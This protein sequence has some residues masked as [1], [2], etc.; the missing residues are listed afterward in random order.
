[1][2]KIYCFYI[3]LWSSF[4]SIVL[5][6]VD[7]CVNIFCWL[8]HFWFY[9]FPLH[10]N[11]VYLFITVL[12]GKFVFT[13]IHSSCWLSVV[14]CLSLHDYSGHFLWIWESCHVSLGFGYDAS[15][16]WHPNAVKCPIVVFWSMLIIVPYL[17]SL[18]SLH[19][20]TTVDPVCK[21]EMLHKNLFLC[22]N[23]A[24]CFLIQHGYPDYY[25]S[26]WVV[27]LILAISL[28]WAH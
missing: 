19:F 9:I 6:A 14:C 17:H 21:R 15:N 25:Q 11:F 7:C 12:F 1:M 22:L 26:L 28:L 18:P 2:V 5:K 3:C 20:T 4:L 8:Y 13:F 16:F 27:C 10:F 23:G 24:T